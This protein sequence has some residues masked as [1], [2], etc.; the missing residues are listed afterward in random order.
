[1]ALTRCLD[2]RVQICLSARNGDSVIF[3]VILTHSE[4]CV[5]QAE[6]P[7]IIDIPGLLSCRAERI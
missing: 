7:G 1:M 4:G 3:A 2:A 5:Y 6:R